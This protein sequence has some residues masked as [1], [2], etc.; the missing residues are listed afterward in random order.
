MDAATAMR[1]LHIPGIA[2]FW[3]GAQPSRTHGIAEAFAAYNKVRH[4]TKQ[5]L[6]TLTSAG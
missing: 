6:Q 2:S 1:A 5:P 3:G 4:E